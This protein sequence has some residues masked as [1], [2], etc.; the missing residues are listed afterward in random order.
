MGYGKGVDGA[1]CSVLCVLNS[2][3]SAALHGLTKDFKS[4]FSFQIGRTKVRPFCLE[5]LL[6]PKESFSQV[7]LHQ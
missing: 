6:F 3:M 7:A 4:L 2:V 5:E 1:K